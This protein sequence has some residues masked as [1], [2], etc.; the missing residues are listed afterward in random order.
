MRNCKHIR[1]LHQVYAQIQTASKTPQLC[2]KS[3]L[4]YRL[5]FGRPCLTRGVSAIFMFLCVPYM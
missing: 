5:S 1:V 2:G 4:R 3:I